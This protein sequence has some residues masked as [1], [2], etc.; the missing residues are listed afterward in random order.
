MIEIVMA[1]H[2][3]KSEKCKIEINFIQNVHFHIAPVSSNCLLFF[4][5]Y[6]FCKKLLT[7]G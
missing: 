7:F 5:F 1:K 6:F 3:Q 2:F 4:F